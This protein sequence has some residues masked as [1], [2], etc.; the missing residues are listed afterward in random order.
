MDKD[1]VGPAVCSQDDGLVAADQ[2]VSP[3]DLLVHQSH[4]SPFIL[5]AGLPVEKRCKL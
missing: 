5:L 3:R 4:C 2:R 1:F